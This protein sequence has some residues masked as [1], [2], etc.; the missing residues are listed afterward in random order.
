M[1]CVS[2]TELVPNSKTCKPP[3]RGA[4]ITW[5]ELG[6]NSMWTDGPTSSGKS[7]MGIRVGVFDSF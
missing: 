7:S 6:V 5:V 1:F 2:M 4:K 3:E